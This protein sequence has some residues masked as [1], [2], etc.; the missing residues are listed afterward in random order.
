MEVPPREL[1]RVP[2]LPRV[3]NVVI[4][5]VVIT[6]SLGVAPDGAPFDRLDMWGVESADEL[7]DLIQ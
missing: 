5:G 3:L 7:S 6:D 2:Q 4:Q 1:R